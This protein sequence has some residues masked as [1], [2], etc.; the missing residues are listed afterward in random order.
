MELRVGTLKIDD[1]DERLSDREFTSVGD[2]R[3]VHD[4]GFSWLPNGSVDLVLTDPPFNIARDTNFHTYEGN[5]INSYRFDADKGWDSYSPDNFK[6]LLKQW[7]VEFERVLR[8]GGSFAI[9]CADEYLSDLISALKLAKLKPRRT[10]TW[11]KPNA[12]PV[13]RKHMM[14]SA[15]EYIVLGVKGSKSV[16]NA[17]ISFSNQPILTEQEIVAIADKASTVV[18]QE[19]RKALSR[20]GDRPSVGK[21]EEIVSNV[22]AMN[23]EAVDEG[24]GDAIASFEFCY[25]GAQGG[26]DAC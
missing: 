25:S 23:A 5:T 6:D 26:D 4:T 3:L 16:F 7:S 22:V 21:I 9:F 20:L 8:P 1:L 15:C 10:L 14:M 11:R 18:G 12:V 19:I 13:N 17:D 2:I 24:D